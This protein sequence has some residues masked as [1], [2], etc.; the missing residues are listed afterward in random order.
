MTSIFGSRGASSQIFGTQ[1][2]FLN[3]ELMM[4][5]LWSL[6]RP[7][8]QHNQRTSKLFMGSAWSC[9]TMKDS[10]IWNVQCLISL[11]GYSKK[12]YGMVPKHIIS[13]LI[14]LISTTNGLSTL[15]KD[16]SEWMDIRLD[17]LMVKLYSTMSVLCTKGSEIWTQQRP[18]I[19][20]MRLSPSL[21]SSTLK[22][23]Q[24]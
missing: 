6:T 14:I 19:S 21:M 2:T 1:K 5:D 18:W 10:S 11:A 23:V 3:G 22:W 17:S 13:Q 16:C 24:A 12:L 20:I 4:R 15:L 9:R 8:I 7:L